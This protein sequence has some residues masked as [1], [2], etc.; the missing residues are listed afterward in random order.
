MSCFDEE[1]AAPTYG[2]CAAEIKRLEDKLAPAKEALRV[3]MVGEE[4]GYPGSLASAGQ[5]RA[6]A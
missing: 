5:L 6:I 1:P 4:P 3:I 2:E